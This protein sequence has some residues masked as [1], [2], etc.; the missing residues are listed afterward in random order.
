MTHAAQQ[1]ESI[2]DLEFRVGPSPDEYARLLSENEDLKA[3]LKRRSMTAE[4]KESV[5]RDEI[6]EHLKGRSQRTPEQIS[7]SLN[8]PP[9]RV[10]RLL[11]DLRKDGLVKWVPAWSAST[12]DEVRAAQDDAQDGE[13]GAELVQ[14]QAL[15]AE[16]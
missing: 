1:Q 7:E 14:E 6:V 8:M 9:T 2:T 10:A 4:Q 3:K 13:S 12:P 15:H 11:R 16:F 5:D